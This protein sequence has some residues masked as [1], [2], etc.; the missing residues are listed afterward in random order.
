MHVIVWHG[1][2]KDGYKSPQGVH[3]TKREYL[4][5]K[6]DT[7]VWLERA[8]VAEAFPQA[9]ESGSGDEI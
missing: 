3:H 9:H 1:M 8:E 4:L 2:I 6:Q 5:V 7:D